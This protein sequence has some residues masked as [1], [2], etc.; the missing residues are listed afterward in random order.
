MPKP[1]EVIR[2]IGRSSKRVAVS[3]VG[4]AL[5]AAGLAGLIFPILPGWLLIIV[6]LA[7]LASEYAWARRLLNTAKDRAK[8]ARD[9]IRW[10]RK[11]KDPDP[12]LPAEERQP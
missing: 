11:P 5:L 4:F 3:I 12:P 8:R 9:K 6:G 1:S 7:V 2:F 10:R